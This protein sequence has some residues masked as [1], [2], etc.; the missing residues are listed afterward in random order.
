MSS[1]RRRRRSTRALVHVLL[2]APLCLPA[3]A[4]S[5]GA[6]GDD[7]I[8]A[9]MAVEVDRNLEGLS[10]DT[11]ERPYFLGYWVQDQRDV[12]IQATCGSLTRFRSP[13]AGMGHALTFPSGPICRTMPS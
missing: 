3:R 12:S 1:R 10:L 13:P 8:M 9:A 2:F 7:P 4:A 11:L 6:V 5:D